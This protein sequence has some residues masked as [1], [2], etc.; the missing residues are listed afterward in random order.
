[1][2]EYHKRLG[3][4]VCL[5]VIGI[6]LG[7]IVLLLPSY[8]VARSRFVNVEFRTK[9]LEGKLAEIRDKDSANEVKNVADK[10]AALAPLGASE[11]AT[12]VFARFNTTLTS[13]I[14]IT[15]YIYTLNDDKSITLNVLG[16][17]SNRDALVAFT[18]SVNR[19]KLFT[20]ARVPLSSLRSDNDIRFEFK[21]GVVPP[22]SQ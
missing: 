18:D 7:G 13:G 17:A 5:F 9:E 14:R 22:T 8:I 4:T 15:Q 11:N 6:A 20:G 21:L 19:S 3:I 16:T 2:S 12:T 10:I 1:M